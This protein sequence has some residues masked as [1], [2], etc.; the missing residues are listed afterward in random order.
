M[1]DLDTKE[2]IAKVTQKVMQSLELNQPSEAS[3]KNGIFATVDQAVEQ[4]W[5]AQ[6]R[7]STLTLQKREEIIR[8]MREIIKKKGAPIAELVV[9]ETGMGRVKDKVVKQLLAAEKTPGTEDLPTGAFSGDHGLTIVEHAPFGVIGSITPVTNPTATVINN[10][11]GMVAAGNAVVFNCHPSAA[12][13]TLRV[14][15]LLNEGIIAQGGPPNLLTA[16]EKPTIDTAKEIMNHPCIPMLVATGGRAVV[17]VI[18]SSG[19]KAIGAGAGNPP[20]VV[21]ETAN[22]AKAARDI[23]AGASIDNNLHCIAEKEIIAVSSIADQLLEQFSNENAVV[24]GSEWIEPLTRLLIL[25]DDQGQRVNPR[26]IGKDIQVIL[27]DLN[28]EVN[29]DIRMAVIEVG[30]D[31]PLV[32]KEQLMPVIPLVRVGDVDEAIK[33][34]VEVEQGNR[35]T[36]M[37]HSADVNNMTKFARSIQTTLFVKNAP[38][39][40]GIGFGGEG[41]TCFTIAGPTGEGLTSARWFTRIRRCVLVDA[42]SIV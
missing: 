4:A 30:R 7:L 32:L 2:L 34:A 1:G 27:K 9:Q 20:V 15:E 18:M 38:S 28:H 36:A 24:L 25:D 26:Y 6:S 12:S 10:A 13:C 42:L 33:L 21:D 29:E 39:Y 41:H 17:K 11:I 23:I 40:A 37:M 5:I 31:H 22:I 16:V 3:G 19:K 35:H 14:I 8:G